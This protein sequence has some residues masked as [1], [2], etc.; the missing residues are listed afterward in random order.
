M[1]HIPID[2]L[3]LL[4]LAFESVAQANHAATLQAAGGGTQQGLAIDQQQGPVELYLAR[5][6]VLAPV[7]VQ[8]GKDIGT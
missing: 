1:H 5:F 6:F 2:P 4:H 3:R 7:H 8:P